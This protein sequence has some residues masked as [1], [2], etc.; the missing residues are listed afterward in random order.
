[1][2]IIL[3]IPVF[4]PQKSVLNKILEM[5]KIQTVGITDVI[6]INSGAD[7]TADCKVI[8]IEKKTFN[9]ATTRN[10][11]L[12]FE[13]DF[14][15]FMTQD[16]VPVDQFLVEKLVKPFDD[17]GVVLSYARQIPLAD[18]DLIEQYAR[19]KNYPEHSIVKSMETLP[20][21]GIKTF[22]C[23]NSCSLYRGNYF[24]KSC[25]FKD[26]LNTNE[27]ME[28]AARAILDG[29]K[30]FYN[31][32]AKVLHSHNHTF[33]SLFTRYFQ[34]GRFFKNNPWI[35]DTVN[36]H[37]PLQQTGIKQAVEELKFILGKNKLLLPKSIIF[38]LLKYT[39]YKL[40]NRL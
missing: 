4:N 23:S 9:H 22:F 30:I 12:N 3:T 7:F 5:I 28:F 38:S 36:R 1:M 40:G 6:F 25:G 27:D 16:A 32:E 13:A 10:I 35:M 2:K 19:N 34:I 26:G 39:G 33:Y 37:I 20:E 29:K 24:R 31:H 18:A 8:K 14:Y 21:M 11:P 15:M 17:D